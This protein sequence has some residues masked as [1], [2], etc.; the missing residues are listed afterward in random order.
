[1]RRSGSSGFTLVE[2]MIVIAIVGLMLSVSVLTFRNLTKAN[3]RS[4]AARLAAA[5]RFSFDRA[6]MTGSYLRLAIDLDKGLIWIESSKDRV[7]LRSG[8]EQH[9]TNRPTEDEQ[10]RD[11]PSAGSGSKLPLG[12]GFG[13]APAEGE[14][15]PPAIDVKSLVKAYERD[16]KPLERARARFARLRGPGAK[17]I[18]LKGKVIVDAVM[19]A[20]M[21]EPVTKGLAFIYFFPQG[22]T[23]PAIVHLRIDGDE[24]D[25]YSVVLHPL[26][27][28][29]KVFACRYR[30]PEEFG[31]GDDE[32]RRRK[33]G[34]EGCEDAP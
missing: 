17:A 9:A 12:L 27:G 3:L 4:G 20:R 32:G 26:T 5:M 10:Q 31:E 11:A 23:E 34:K 6:L 19:T 2:M 24:D 29:A 18:K 14:E 28:Q 22:H 13:A 16:V 8:R 25:Y 30:I 33:R 15:A 7:A 1:M 21:E